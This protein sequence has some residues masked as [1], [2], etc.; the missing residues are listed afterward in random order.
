MNK[1]EPASYI[2]GKIKEL[3]P[4]N[5]GDRELL[6]TRVIDTGID[7]LELMELIMEI[8][9]EYNIEIADS[10]LSD[11]LTVGSFCDLVTT[12]SGEL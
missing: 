11:D 3:S 5:I 7:S 12:L 8:E 4:Q 1:T 9:G 2:L 10:Q 6:K